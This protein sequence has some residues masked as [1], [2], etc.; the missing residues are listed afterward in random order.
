MYLQL[1][2]TAAM[3]KSCM[4]RK[5]GGREGEREG[6]KVRESDQIQVYKRELKDRERKERKLAQQ[7]FYFSHK[8]I[9]INKYKTVTKLYPTLNHIHA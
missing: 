2:D 8:I 7:L 4:Y 3:I 6:E 1:P 5:R 9:A